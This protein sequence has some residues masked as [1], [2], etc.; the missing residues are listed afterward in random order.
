MNPRQST[1]R[2]LRSSGNAESIAATPAE[3]DTATVRTG[4]PLHVGVRVSVPAAAET[5]VVDLFFYSFED[6]VLHAQCSTEASRLPE[7]LEGTCELE[8]QVP[9]LGLQPG[10]YTVDAMAREEGEWQPDARTRGRATLYVTEGR[11]VDG[12]FFMPHSVRLIEPAGLSALDAGDAG[13]AGI[14]EGR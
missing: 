11:G 7:R 8:F 13:Q 9:A 6:G 14:A 3:T 2:E 10:V 12:R 1:T 4:D 5:P